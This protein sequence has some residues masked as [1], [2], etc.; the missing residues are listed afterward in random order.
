MVASSSS[1]SSLCVSSAA[2][3]LVLVAHSAEMM[4]QSQ[5]S[6]V[7]RSAWAQILSIPVLAL[8][9]SLLFLRRSVYPEAE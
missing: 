7:P 1:S 8:S 9:V 2:S 5:A 4:G 6:P 3:C